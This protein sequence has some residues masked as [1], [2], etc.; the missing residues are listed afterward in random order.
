MHFSGHMLE[1]QFFG[2]YITFFVVPVYTLYL[3]IL[4]PEHDTSNTGTVTDRVPPR[5]VCVTTLTLFP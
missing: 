5:G 3:P 4:D 2:G 1:F